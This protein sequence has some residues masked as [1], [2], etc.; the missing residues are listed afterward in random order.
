MQ[1]GVVTVYGMVGVA[2]CLYQLME[3]RGREYAGVGLLLCTVWWEWLH[4]SIS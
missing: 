4:F 3:A 2:P 1:G